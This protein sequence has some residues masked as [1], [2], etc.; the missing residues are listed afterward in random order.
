[1][2]MVPI[3]KYVQYS[4]AIELDIQDHAHGAS[5]RARAAPIYFSARE[6]EGVILYNF[7]NSLNKL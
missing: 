7:S 5:S 3:C 2:G 1:M 4:E 6:L